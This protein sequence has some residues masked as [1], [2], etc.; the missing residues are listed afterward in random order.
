MTS[1]VTWPHYSLY[2][3]SYTCFIG[4][5]LDI[6]AAVLKVWSHI[7]N[8]IPSTYA[9]LRLSRHKSTQ[10]D[11]ICQITLHTYKQHARRTVYVS[12]H[13]SLSLA[14]LYGVRSYETTSTIAVIITQPKSWYSFSHPSEGRK[15]SRPRWL[16]I[17]LICFQA[18]SR[19]LNFFLQNSSTFKDF[20]RTLWTL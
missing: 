16:V 20:A 17:Y 2:S 4:A 11:G 9:D 15:L 6:M 5:P 14:R 1:L 7:K 19:A 3:I 18:L 13:V 12:L 10:I 8:P